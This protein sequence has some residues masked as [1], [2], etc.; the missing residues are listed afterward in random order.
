MW[1]I[2]V[3]TLNNTQIQIPGLHL[4][5][6]LPA[7]VTWYWYM[8]W[9]RPVR[10]RVKFKLHY[11]CCTTAALNP[12]DLIFKSQNLGNCKFGPLF[13]PIKT[14]LNSKTQIT[15]KR[16]YLDSTSF[17]C[18][19]SCTTGAANPRDLI[20]KSRNENWPTV[21]LEHAKWFFCSSSLSTKTLCYEVCMYLLD[22]F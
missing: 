16:G 11:R 21:N 15:L 14:P 9:F 18:S 2:L 3:K 1:Y 19:S 22:N 5:L 4:T 17:C 12:R 13:H 8:G 10:N 7:V 20:V 6:F